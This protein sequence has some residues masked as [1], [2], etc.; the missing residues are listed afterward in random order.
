MNTTTHQAVKKVV[1]GGAGVSLG[2]WVKK[3]NKE[4]INNLR[5]SRSNEAGVIFKIITKQYIV[6]YVSMFV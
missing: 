1:E 6:I 5:A 4:K 2:L 3:G